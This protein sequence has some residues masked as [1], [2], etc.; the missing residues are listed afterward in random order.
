[1][2]FWGAT[3]GTRDFQSWAS[4][5]SFFVGDPSTM[6]V[7]CQ[8]LKRYF[9]KIFLCAKSVKR[10]FDTLGSYAHIASDNSTIYFYFPDFISYCMSHRLPR[11]KYLMHLHIY[12]PPS[13]HL[14]SI[15]WFGVTGL[16][17]AFTKIANSTKL[18]LQCF[19]RCIL[20]GTALT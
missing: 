20:F 2:Y 10:S 4:I 12:R 11:T 8:S 19:H 15:Y 5:I 1:M 14:D 9:D 13:P 7:P 16:T 3:P 17:T 6:S 18:R